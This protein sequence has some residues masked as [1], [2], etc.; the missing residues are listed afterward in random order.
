MKPAAAK[1]IAIT[2][3][4]MPAATL[5]VAICSE[6]R[7][8][9]TGVSDAADAVHR[10]HGVGRVGG[11]GRAERA[12][13]DADVRE[14]SAARGLAYLNP[15]LGARMAAAGAAAAD[16]ELAIGATFAGHRIDGVAGRGGMGL[17]YRATDL[18][19]DRPV[20]LKLIAS[21]LAR[22][23]VYRA[24][25]ERECRIAAALD[26]PHV[27]SFLQAGAERGRL[28]V[29]MRYVGGTDLHKLL[30]TEGRLAPRR[31]VAL[32]RQVAAGL[33]EAHARG[34]VH[35][36]VKPGNVLIGRR[37][38]G[39]HAYLTDFGVTHERESSV[40]LTATGFAVGTADYMA[41]EQA[42]GAQVD[43]RAD[44]YSLACVLFRALTGVVL[45]DRASE[46]DKLMAH[47]YEPPPSL[48]DVDPELPAGLAEVVG[49]AL[50][51]HPGERHLTAGAFAAEAAAAIA[52]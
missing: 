39:E 19:L 40:H 48:L 25:F 51:K 18:S 6:R 21:S 30:S 3:S 5:S 32:V 47:I 11:D 16:D 24:R 50:A 42:Q 38:G 26:H 7:P 37:G 10:H 31:A 23:P 41:P 36:D 2:L 49:R 27:V 28:Y 52:R 15:R 46:L 8:I 22:D 43:A 12:H 17:V 34:L 44:I 29:T 45:Y 35:R 13:R 33:D 14:R 4:P 1:P 20:A 9:A